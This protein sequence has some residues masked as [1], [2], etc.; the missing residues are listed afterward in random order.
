MCIRRKVLLVVGGRGG[1]HDQCTLDLLRS[2]QHDSKNESSMSFSQS[3]ELLNSC[4][5]SSR[6][7]LQKF[8]LHI[9][10][11]DLKVFLNSYF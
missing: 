3:A 8:Q 6:I 9:R 10:K 7:Y 2:A 1:Y 5:G 4:S 11:N